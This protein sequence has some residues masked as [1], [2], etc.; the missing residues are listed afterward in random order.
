MVLDA[1]SISHGKAS[2]YLPV[3]D[4]LRNYF[5]IS[6]SDDDRKRREKVAGKIAMLDRNLEDSLP[7]LFSLLGIVEGD[8]PL[9]QMDGQIKKRR[10]LEAIKRILLRESLNQPLM[11]TFEDLHWMDGESEA[12]LNLLAG[13]IAT[14][15]ILLLV[16]YRPEYGHQWGSKTYY[17]Q[18]RLDSLDSSSADEMLSTL[19]GNDVSLVPLKRLILGKTEGNPLFMEEIV[20]S[21]FE[22]G[23]LARNG[24][25][26]LAKPLASLRIPPTLQAI[27]VSRID[28]LPADEK[29]FLQTVAVIGADFNR[30][31]ARSISGKSDDDL[32]RILNN[33]QLAE[34]IY[35]QPAASDVEY[36]FKHALTHEVAYNSILLQRRKQ[37]HE[38]TA[39]TLETIHTHDRA[40]FFGELARHYSRSDNVGKAVEYLT[41]AGEQSATR[42]AF[43]EAATYTRNALELVPRLAEG[44]DRAELRLQ[45]ALASAQAAIAGWGSSERFRSL[46]RA[47]ELCDGL[48]ND[49]EMFPVLLQLCQ[50]YMHAGRY[51]EAS[52]FADKS[53]RLAE[54]KADRVE[55]MLAHYSLGECTFRMGNFPSARLHL[56]RA[57]EVFN[58]NQDTTLARQYGFV[59]IGTYI[60]YW[61][62]VNSALAG[63]VDQALQRARSAV[64]RARARD[65]FS[66]TIALLCLCIVHVS[67]REPEQVIGTA[68]EALALC[69]QY[70][71]H[72]LEAFLK[73][74]HGWATAVLGRSREGIAEVIAGVKETQAA[75]N[76]DPAFAMGSL[77]ATYL[78]AGYS[79]EALRAADEGLQMMACT[80]ERFTEFP[81]LWSKGGALSRLGRIDEAM[82]SLSAAIDVA[83]KQEAK[84][85]ELVATTSMAR[86][87][88]SQDRR[89][90]ARTMLAE[91]YNWFTEGFDTRDL[92]DAKALLDEL[93]T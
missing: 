26:K 33:L 28:R 9:A 42:S 40:D 49:R 89:D 90:E 6:A 5:E 45:L 53:K 48:E 35:E 34:F 76:P 73:L 43:A 61:L 20:L 47:S 14:A 62:S 36:T 77:A 23:A 60:S 84:L 83:R 30:S 13:S 46:E 39:S 82:H 65:P 4:L 56:E 64:A 71:F 58:D 41:L 81:L 50:T 1:L 63:C 86:L 70:A 31:A 22:D 57:L 88:A 7:Y 21:L 10:T 18:L 24:D 80:G 91:I 38:R 17:T 72:E 3:I 8:D 93:S 85:Y 55:L 16:N 52:E 44:R 19:M 37:I 29:D 11:V 12:L 32:D 68:S 74:S 51:A 59:D 25:V 27:L 2:A 79:A 54:V 66:L 69:A 15:R 67:R 87:L 75:G 92:K 78:S